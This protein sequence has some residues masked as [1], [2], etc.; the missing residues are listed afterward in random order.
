MRPIAMRLASLNIAIES[1]TP[2][3]SA[4]KPL[5]AAMAPNRATTAAAIP[6]VTISKD[7]KSKRAKTNEDGAPILR[8]TKTS[9]RLSLIEARSMA[10]NPKMDEMKTKIDI[11]RKVPSMP[12]TSV[13]S[14]ANATPGKI[15]RS[16]SP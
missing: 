3:W 1:V 14:C 16:A 13:H 5:T 10:F 9:L 8:N 12:P 11:P 6:M 2:I 4:K 7:S 15:A